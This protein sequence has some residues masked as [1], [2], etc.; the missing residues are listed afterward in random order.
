MEK[1]SKLW[2]KKIV[3]NF[4]YEL[5]DRYTYPSHLWVSDRYLYNKVKSYYHREIIKFWF[6]E[7]SAPDRAGFDSRSGRLFWWL[8]PSRNGWMC[9][10]LSSFSP[11]IFDDMIL[12]VWV[13]LF[14]QGYMKRHQ[15]LS[16]NWCLSIPE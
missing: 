1:K 14:K 15:N 5:V 12:A 3:I 10:F 2:W 8:I 9:P 11:I 6:S 7:P 4:F 13:P 16:I